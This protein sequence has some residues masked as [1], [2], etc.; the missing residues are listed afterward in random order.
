V[1]EEIPR[2]RIAAAR[3]MLGPVLRNADLHSYYALK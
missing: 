1:S 3:V 2:N